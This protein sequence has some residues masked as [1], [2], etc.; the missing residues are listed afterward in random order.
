MKYILLTPLFLLLTIAAKAQDCHYDSEKA[1][2][3]T[4]KSTK[5]INCKLARSWRMVFTKQDTELNIGLFMI[6][7]GDQSL[8]INE[9]DS[10]VM[11]LESGDVITLHSKAVYGPTA[12]AG[13]S[14]QYRQIY[15]SY[16]PLYLCDVADM[17]KLSKS[18]IAAM[19]IFFGGN[20]VTLESVKG[21]LAD[22]IMDA[23][24]CIRH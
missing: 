3:I 21:K 11:R 7:P 8:K 20:P 22:K 6:L 1:D 17:K 18:P 12:F 13:G 10:L 9:G 19:R 4:G 16:S 24:Y 23:A 15:S 5:V 14:S 2:P